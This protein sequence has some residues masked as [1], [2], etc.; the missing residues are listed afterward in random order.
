MADSPFDIE[1]TCDLDASR[2][3]VYRAF[4][5]P[6][7]FAQWYGPA[8][9][10]VDTDSVQL[11]P[12]VDGVQRFAMVGEE[13]PSMRTEWDGGFTDVVVNEL[14]ASSG[15]WSGIPGRTDR[16]ESNLRVEFHARDGKTR[17]VIKE[18]PHPPGTADLGRQAWKMMC[19]KLATLMAG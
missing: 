9:F 12:R 16:W 13:D 5:V 11:D 15:S 10:P 2:E 17:L 18:G 7:E 8:G 1:V 3:R 4:T 6:D 14:L 19:A